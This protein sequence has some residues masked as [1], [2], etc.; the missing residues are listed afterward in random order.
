M[1]CFVQLAESYLSTGA[2]PFTNALAM[3]GLKAVKSSLVR[4]VRDGS[5]PEARTEMAFAALTSGI[6]LT[7][8]GLGV[9]HGFASS[10]GGMADIP[11]GVICGTLM[12]VSN[13]INVRE[14]RK[15]DSN[16]GAL[17]KYAELGR[18]FLLDE[19][20]SDD[21][22]VDG[23][24]SYLHQLT[25]D[26]QL[27]GLKQY[28]VNESDLKKICMATSVKSNPVDLSKDD[29]LEILFHRFF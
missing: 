1:D 15:R 2:N 20:K 9:I 18:L 4:C 23:F 21:Y 24:V 5:N 28:G 14:L 7:N 12:A 11:H 8:A 13:E 19:G 3:E 27:P 6:C 10:L 22:Y 29:L 26:F 16:Q 17:K 25:K